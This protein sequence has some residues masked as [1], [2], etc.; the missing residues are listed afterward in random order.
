MI[1]GGQF[2]VVFFRFPYAIYYTME[3]ELVVFVWRILDMRRTPEK[4]KKSLE[5]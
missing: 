5:F 2:S 1:G 3:N 4:I